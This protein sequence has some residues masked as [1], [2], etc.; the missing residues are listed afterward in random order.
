MVEHSQP[1]THKA[2]HAGHL[3]N[4]CLGVSLGK[5]LRAAGYDVRDANYIGDIGMHVVKCLWCYERFHKGEEPTEAAAK[6][7]WLGEIYADSDA[8]LNFRKDVLEFLLLL[9]TEDQPSSRRST[10]C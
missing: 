6:G 2:F 9:S 4:S 3:R 10:G 8:R 1:N 7:R 5:I